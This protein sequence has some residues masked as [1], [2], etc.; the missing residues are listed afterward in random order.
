[1]S[2]P[3]C[4]TKLIRAA[5]RAQEVLEGPIGDH[6]TGDCMAEVGV[7]DAINAL[8]SALELCAVEYPK[9]AGWIDP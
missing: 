9:S 1:M 8:S 5:R 6:L 2:E 4:I 3:K 7:Y